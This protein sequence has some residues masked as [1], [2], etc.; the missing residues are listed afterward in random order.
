MKKFVL[1]LLVTFLSFSVLAD[2][3]LDDL[4]IVVT[5]IPKSGTNLLARCIHLLT[6]KILAN[7]FKPLF[8]NHGSKITWHGPDSQKWDEITKDIFYFSH[9]VYSQEIRDALLKYQYKHVFI[10]RDPRD[11]VVSYYYWSKNWPNVKP[12]Y[13]ND[14][15]H[16]LITDGDFV[17]G[18]K[19]VNTLFN[20]Y[21]PWVEECCYAVRF[22]DLVGPKGG[23]NLKAQIRE[24]KNIAEFIGISITE[25]KL[26]FVVDHLFGNTATFRKG[27]I[28]AWKSNFTQKHKDAFKNVAGQLL[29][30]LGYEKDFNW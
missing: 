14:Y 18:C 13:G 24:I 26:Q 8:E 27:Q 6:G 7:N 17:F 3:N 22:E 16:Y 5:S 23:G 10:Y 29:I 28:G 19:N 12:F 1:I 25:E 9:M 21:L 30:D 2:T 4:R 11:Q 15:I 20:M